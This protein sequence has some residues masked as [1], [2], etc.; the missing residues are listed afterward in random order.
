VNVN[1][2]TPTGAVRVYVPAAVFV[3]VEAAAA[4]KVALVP[5]RVPSEAFS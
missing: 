5:V 4:V 1:E 3:T 2:V